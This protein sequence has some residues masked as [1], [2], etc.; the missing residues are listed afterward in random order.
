MT[1]QMFNPEQS[2][3]FLVSDVARLLRR[4]FDRRARRLGLSQAQWRALAQLSRQEGVK[5]VT[6]AES[7][8]IQP[9]TLVRLIDRLQEAGLVAR[10]PDP[11]DR[12]A[13]RLYLTDAAR[14]LLE[15]MWDLAAET[16]DEVMA[17]MPERQKE[18]LF[19]ALRHMKDNLLAAENGG[20]NQDQE[21]E[22]PPSNAA[23][24]T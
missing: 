10:R 9:I 7:L 21:A 16:R 11:E 24:G 6:L 13:F 18:A 12:R 23:T 5:Q 20:E 1:A 19:A 4:N 17:G 14:P 15:Q 8:D 22:T 2:I 3:G